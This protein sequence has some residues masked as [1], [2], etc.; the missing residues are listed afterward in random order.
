MEQ[1]STNVRFNN[2]LNKLAPYKREKVYNNIKK[3]SVE[4]P[5]LNSKTYIAIIDKLYK[6]DISYMDISAATYMSAVDIWNKFIV[7]SKENFDLLISR[8]D[9]V[10]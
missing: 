1:L 3:L 6:K 2:A 7:E 5:D 4:C 8:E 9:L 10:F